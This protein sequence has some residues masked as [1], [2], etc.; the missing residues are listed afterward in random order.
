MARK[1]NRCCY[2]GLYSN[3]C[4]LKKVKYSSLVSVRFDRLLFDETAEKQILPAVLTVILCAEIIF[5]FLL[6]YLMSLLS[7]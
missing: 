7:S 4:W 3:R 2:I 1:Q 5:L 6:N